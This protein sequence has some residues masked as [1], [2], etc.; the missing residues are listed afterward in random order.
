MYQLLLKHRLFFF[1]L[2]L[3]SRYERLFYFPYLLQRWKGYSIIIYMINRPIH[4]TIFIKDNEKQYFTHFIQNTPLSNRLHLIIYE[5]LPMEQST[6][7]CIVYYHELEPIPV[8]EIVYNSSIV[9]GNRTIDGLQRRF[10]RICNDNSEAIYPINRLRNLAIQ[11]IETTHFL[12][13]DMDM[14]PIGKERKL[15]Y[16]E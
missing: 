8:N 4:A 14:W 11:S 15:S 2:S 9:Y 5:V 6:H 1:V 13:I 7:Q 16:N 3:L 10:Q 12:V